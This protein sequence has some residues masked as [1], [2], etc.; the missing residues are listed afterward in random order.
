MGLVSG[1]ILEMMWIVD[2]WVVMMMWLI[3]CRWFFISGC[4]CMVVLVV[5]CVWNLVGKLILNS[6]FFIM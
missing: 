1:L 3:C 2:L 6:M 5:V 4:R